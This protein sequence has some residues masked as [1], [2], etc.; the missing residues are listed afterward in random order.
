MCSLEVCVYVFH[1]DTLIICFVSYWTVTIIIQKMIKGALRT[2]RLHGDI[3]AQ[4]L[5]L[6]NLKFQNN[7]ESIIIICVNLYNYLF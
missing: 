5:T 3:Y 4:M 6:S 2:K 7:F 1:L